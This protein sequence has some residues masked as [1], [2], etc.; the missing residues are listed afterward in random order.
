VA[1]SNVVLVFLL[2]ILEINLL[3]HLVVLWVMETYLVPGT[4]TSQHHRRRV[5]VD[6]NE[7]HFNSAEHNVLDE[8]PL[9]S[10]EYAQRSE[11]FRSD[12]GLGE[13]RE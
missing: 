4:S 2:K 6:R 8:E 7:I 3:S 11:P 9:N 12:R 10:A 1:V 13:R 5:F